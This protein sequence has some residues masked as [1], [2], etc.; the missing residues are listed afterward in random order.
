MKLSQLILASLFSLT[1]TSAFAQGWNDRTPEIP[2]SPSPYQP[3]NGPCNTEHGWN[4]R[5]PE[6]PVHASPY[7]PCDQQCMIDSL[8]GWN[9]K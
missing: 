3:C 2:V 7:V 9:D 4:D 1:V 8:K 6:I 5:G